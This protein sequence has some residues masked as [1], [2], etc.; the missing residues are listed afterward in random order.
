[1]QHVLERHTANNIPKFANKSKFIAGVNLKELIQRG[2]Q[3]PMIPQANGN[4]SRTFDAGKVIGIDRA[5]GQTTSTVTII[6]AP[7]TDLVTMFPGMP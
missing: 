1:L 6:T 7:N 3:M 2:T 4:F 5:T